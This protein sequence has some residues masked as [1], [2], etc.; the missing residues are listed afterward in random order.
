M[1]GGNR[2]AYP[3]RSHRSPL[4]T[5]SLSWELA[6]W[7]KSRGSP[8]E[9]PRVPVRW[10]AVRHL[11]LAAALALVAAALVAALLLVGREGGGAASVEGVPAAPLPGPPD[12][13]LVGEQETAAA[14]DPPSEPTRAAVSYVPRPDAAW[15][16]GRVYGEDD[17]PL[18]GIPVRLSFLATSGDNA[19]EAIPFARVTTDHAGVF[20]TTA[21]ALA[22]VD[23][24]ARAYATVQAV[25]E[26]PTWVGEP[27]VARADEELRLW[28][29]PGFGVTGRTVD[30]DGAAVAG[31]R[32]VLEVGHARERRRIE[33]RSGV[34][35]RFRLGIGRGER[36]L[37]LVAHR[38]SVGRATRD[39]ETDE[40][41]RGA[42][43]LGDV[44]LEELGVLAGRAFDRSALPAPHARIVAVP[45]EL[46]ELGRWVSTGRSGVEAVTDAEGRFR[47]AGLAD[48]HYGL[49]AATLAGDRGPFERAWVPPWSGIDVTVRHHRLVVCVTDTAGRPLPAL[50]RLSW[51]REDLGELVDHSAVVEPVDPATGCIG[52]PVE[53]GDLLALYA[54]AGERVASEELVLVE[55]LPATVRRDLVLPPAATG[56]RVRVRAR[57]TG[58]NELTG[59]SV[60]VQ[61][62]FSKNNLPG[63][64]RV[65][66]DGEGWLPPL[67]PGSYRLVAA[68]EAELA[69]DA[70][71][72][73]G[74]IS[75]TEPV[76][77]TAG[78]VT[79]A[80]LLAIHGG[81]VR[82]TIHVH[83]DH[84]SRETVLAR[85]ASA[86]L[87]RLDARG[88]RTK[89]AYEF[90]RGFEDGT[91]APPRSVEPGDWLI[92]VVALDSEVIQEP[93][94]IHPGR[95][96]RVSVTL[97][98]WD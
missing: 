88:N 96:E 57:D 36:P 43:V 76:V 98:P 56:G 83:D 53:E 63:F 13:P 18:P 16:V 65:E 66:P 70:E 17:E 46:D 52:F 4:R 67:P 90:T 45:V 62:P 11:V 23:V 25:A 37:S 2:G 64:E 6:G 22:F 81:D 38:P 93:V 41:G 49:R 48:A 69:F 75:S 71:R 72:Y 19:G 87:V 28:L 55:A 12:A 60:W 82:L 20:R 21:A 80:E 74:E 78:G 24:E 33:A 50:V 1:A 54:A 92:V 68:L 26:S 32:L 47:I 40:A 44:V 35:G 51:M 77:V 59:Y 85:G 86:R 27:A 29:R 7:R 9:P 89:K 91:I 15:I 42:V 14:P 30:A 10:G 34:D 79:E 8:V 31:A 39:F 95:T 73:F 97:R 5:V 84:P 61:T 58:G 3:R 94:T